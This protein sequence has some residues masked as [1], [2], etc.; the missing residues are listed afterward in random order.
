MSARMPYDNYDNDDQGLFT[1]RSMMMANFEEWI[2]MAT[3]NKINS[4]NSW[5][6][7]LIDYFHDLN[8]LRDSENNINFQ[9]ASATL[10]GCVKIYSSRVDSV[11]N[12]T[13][14]LLSG[15]A[16]K[17][18][19]E[20]QR[21]AD[22]NNVDGGE[23]GNGPEES[24]EDDIQIDP[25]TGLPIAR[26]DDVRTKRRVHNRVL[27]TTLVDFDAIKMKELDQELNIDPLFKKALVDFDEGGAKSLLLNTLN[28]DRDV[29][30]VFDAAL[31][32]AKEKDTGGT[33]GHQR[34]AEDH[35]IDGSDS[36]TDM[37]SGAHERSNGSNTDITNNSIIIE[38]EILA[39]G[40]D[41]IKF[42]DISKCLISTSMQQLPKVV[43]DITKAKTFI[44][45]VNS[46]FDNFLSE[47]ELEEAV[48]DLGL[49]EMEEDNNILQDEFDDQQSDGSS[50]GQ[51]DANDHNDDDTGNNLD[52]KDPSTLEDEEAG[53]A[54]I[55][56]QDL[57]AY[58]DEN[59]TKTWR[60]RE[61]WKVRNFKKN[62]IKGVENNKAL[63]QDKDGNEL[64]ASDEA[65]KKKNKKTS[66]EI[67]FFALDDRLEEAVFASKKRTNIELPQKSR[68]NASHYLL[69]DDFHF[70]TQR[71]TRLFI[72]P[73]QTMSIFRPR[74]G[75]RPGRQEGHEARLNNSTIED[76]HAD[77]ASTPIAD[78]Q[79]WADN[80]QRIDREND[81]QPSE[82]PVNIVTKGPEN[83]FE[84]DEGGVDF[85][86]AFEDEEIKDDDPNL[87]PSEATAKFSLPDNKVN[88][89]R[90]SKKV[91]VK[92][93]K[94]NIWSSIK[95]LA[96][97]YKSQ[98][99]DESTIDEGTLRFS[100]IAVELSKTY[101]TEAKKD[102][103]TSFC[104]ICLLH[105][106]NEHGLKVTS[107]EDYED[108]L[109][110]FPYSS[111]QA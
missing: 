60:G 24:A 12:E 30:V 87:L 6:F 15:L 42:E 48:P 62:M 50:Y 98:K 45:G 17:K 56:E 13:G 107:M 32:D 101:K 74:R 95:T 27:E 19:S 8:V 7:A 36:V 88:F 49:D 14:K 73:Q 86:Q 78:E 58:F 54:G 53:L 69:P 61:H 9:K 46:K 21:H 35:G 84:E 23:G 100:E 89:S 4:R 106:A 67:D 71:I 47:K 85:N 31:R 40:M 55:Y 57:M 81:Q 75:K 2:K 70:T 22:Q 94:D 109:V 5:N 18:L 34:E 1:N 52:A 82:E 92:K 96:N 37:D 83:P 41:Y 97:R 77:R 25:S 91:D 3:D 63:G 20:K 43:E 10:D 80:Y 39:L 33:D 11:T 110:E 90:V 26:G 102:I 51:E 79:F 105:L 93:L 44:D 103:S 64:T 66:Q 76:R 99:T 16:Q 29:R 38:D 108:L 28:I 72:K 59:L 111:L 65:T 104:F 68:T